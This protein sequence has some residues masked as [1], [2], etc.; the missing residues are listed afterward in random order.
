V[1]AGQILEAARQIFGREGF[2]KTTIQAVA[3]AAGI[4]KGTIYLYFDSKEALYWAAVR[5]GLEEMRRQSAAAMAEA[6]STADKLRAFIAT[7]LRYFQQERDFF[8]VYFAELG[9]S[10][11]RSPGPEDKLEEL[12]VGQAR[13][14]R[15]MLDEG[16]AGGEL[17]EQRTDA[18]A[19]AILDLTRACVV[20]RLRGW[21][22]ASADEDLDHIFN[23]LWKGISR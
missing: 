4:G 16:V 20:Q 8:R 23:L 18:T 6:S 5:E 22:R 2:A 15:A 7:R 3:E 10:L 1:R 21:S 14:L 13:S 9:H 11:V 12:Y 17:R 19:Y